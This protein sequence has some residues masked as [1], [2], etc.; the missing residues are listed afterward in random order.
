MS[1]YPR[2]LIGYGR[3]AAAS[4]M[5][6]RR[7]H[8]VQF[9]LNYEEGG[10]NSV[11]HG[12]RGVGDVPVRDRRRA[13]FPDAPHEHGVAV[14][15]RLARRPVA[16]AARVRAAELAADRVRRRRWRCS[17]IRKPSRPSAN[18]GT[19]SPATA[20]A[21]SATSTSTKPPSARTCARPSQSFA[22]SPAPRRSAGTPGATVPN[23]R[24]LVVEHGGFVY[25]ADSYADDLP[26]WTQV[27]RRRDG[28]AVPHLVVPYTL[29]TNDMR[30]A[31]AQ[32]FNSR[33]AVL[34]LSEGCVRRAVSRRRS[35]G[36]DA[37]EDAVDRP[38]LPH[39]RPPGAHRALERFLDYVHEARRRVDLPPHR[40]R[41]ALDRHAS[42][43][44]PQSMITLDDSTRAS[45]RSSSRR[46]AASSSIRRGSPNARSPLRPFD[47][48][49]AAARR[50]CAQS[51]L[52]RRAKSSST[53]IR[54][55]PE[56][57]G[58]AAVRGELTAES[59]TRAAGRRA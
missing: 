25:D 44:A 54:A 9:V 56:L 22:N 40:H 32:G 50:R 59:D 20:C 28:V 7:A 6:R 14:R 43:T 41:A 1:S 35:G 24:R 2:D 17:A 38:A 11:L 12:D 45:G 5:A 21:G 29:D 39:R 4:R 16:R 58:K 47:S 42:A 36:L 18:S 46:W 23:T 53:L 33:H 49:V 51:S 3:D 52:Q 37:P 15:I 34:R 8:R 13:G 57:A 19:R 30:F 26:Y 31:T 48:R 55:H 10:E 27:T